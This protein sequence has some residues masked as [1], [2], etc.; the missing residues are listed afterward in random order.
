VF[1]SVVAFS[2]EAN[3]IKQVKEDVGGRNHWWWL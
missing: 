2:F 3:H 1:V